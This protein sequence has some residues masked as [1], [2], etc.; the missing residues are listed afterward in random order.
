MPVSVTWNFPPLPL[1]FRY[2]TFKWRE[3]PV[4]AEEWAVQEWG[5]AVQEWG[6]AAQEEPVALQTFHAL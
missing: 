1:G 3:A 5:E 6:E 2:S 4:V